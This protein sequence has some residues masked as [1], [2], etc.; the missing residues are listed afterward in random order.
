MIG[1]ILLACALLG[2]GF[3][4]GSDIDDHVIRGSGTSTAR[5]TITNRS[6]GSL[7]VFSN[8]THFALPVPD[9]VLFDCTHNSLQKNRFD[10]IVCDPPYGTWCFMNV[11]NII[12]LIHPLLGLRTNA[13]SGVD[14]DASL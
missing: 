2:A 5:L 3:L 1:T 10:A 9:I 6:S 11:N 12:L 8:F 7:N 13:R 4:C 14:S